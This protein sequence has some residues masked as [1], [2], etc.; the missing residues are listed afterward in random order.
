MI[1]AILVSFGLS[2]VVRAFAMNKIAKG[3]TA[4]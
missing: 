4:A 3:P 2:L 1:K